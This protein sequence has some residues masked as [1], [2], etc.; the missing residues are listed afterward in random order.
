DVMSIA[1][2]IAVSGLN[3]AT[4]RLDVAASNIANA[5]SDGPLPG[6]GN[7]ENFPAAYT[8]LR[9][10]QTDVVGTSATVSA[11]SPATVPAHDPGAP[12]ADSNGMVASPNVD[13]ANELVQLLI[14]RYTFAANAQVI[15]AD[16]QMSAALLNVFA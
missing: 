9:V 5:L 1:S 7:V 3:V 14:A 13:L 6:A 10:N 12:F 15:R 11:V 4:L 8:P 16:A 2:T